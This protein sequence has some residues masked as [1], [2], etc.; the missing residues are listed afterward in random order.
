MAHDV[1]EWLEGLGLGRYAEAFAE[2]EI[3]LPALPHITEEDL[4]EVGVAL[5]ARRLL[6]AAIADLGPS[7]AP[8]QQNVGADADAAGSEAER[9]H[10]TV[11]FCDLVGSTALSEQ[12]DPEDLRQVIA[13]FQ[14]ACASVVADF[15]GY[16]AR[17]MGD[18]MLVYFGYPTAQE[19]AAERSVRAGLGIVDRVTSLPGP[20]GADLHVRVGVATG[21][22]VVGD[23][24][25]EKTA[26]E[27][28]VVGETPNLAARLQG[29]A[30]A[31]TVV[32]APAT[33]RLLGGLFE[34]ED[35]G[36]HDLKGFSEPVRA[37]R[38]LHPTATLSRFEAY[39]G[40][41]L[42]PLV[43]RQE[44]IGFLAEKWNQVRAGEGQVVTLSGEA[45]IG[46][47]RILEAMRAHV[48][49]TDGEAI[50]FQCS[51]HH[52]STALYPFTGYLNRLS[53][54]LAGQAGRATLA[55][56]EALVRSSGQPLAETVP[57]FAELISLPPDD[58]YQPSA[59]DPEQRR[60][61]TLQALA[62]HVKGLTRSSPL[63]LVFEDVHWIDPTSCDLLSQMIEQAASA[64]VLILV[65]FRPGFASPWGAMGVVAHLALSRLGRRQSAD[66]ALAMTGG[67]ALPDEVLGHITDRADG[68]PLFVE[69]MTKSI[70]DSDLMRRTD[71]GFVLEG[72]LSDFAV[73]ETL[74]DSLMARL[75]R[76]SPVK[77]VAQL[78]AVIGREFG[79]GL[80]VAVSNKSDEEVRDAIATL[81]EAELVFRRGW[82]P[83][84][85]YV[86]KH[87]LVQDA[88][89]ESLLKEKRR[90][91]HKAVAMALESK[92][93]ALSEAEPETLAHHLT[94]CGET[95]QAS[96][97]WEKAGR[98]AQE[99]LSHA[100]AA[101][102]ITRALKGVGQDR[103]REFELCLELVSNLRV[104][105]RAEA[106]ERILKRAEPL[107]QQDVDRAKIHYHFGNLYFLSGNSNEALNQHSEALRLARAASSAELECRALSGLADGHYMR[108]RMV[109]AHTQSEECVATARQ[110][111]L[112]HVVASNL[113]ALGNM[114]YLSQGPAAARP[115]FETGVRE[116]VEAENHRAEMIFRFNM[117]AILLDSMELTPALEHAELA[118][119]ACERIGAG[120]WLP[121]MAV[122]GLKVRHLMGENIA[123][124]MLEVAAKAEEIAPAL[125][126]PWA[127]GSLAWAT[128][129]VETATDAMN[130]A[131]AI[132]SSNCVAHN[133]LWFYRDAMDSCLRF[134]RWDQA[135]EY[136]DDLDDFTLAE[137]LAWNR[138]FAAR[139]RALADHGR[140]R[141]S[142]DELRR[143]SEM[144]RNLGFLHSLQAVEGALQ[145]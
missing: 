127:L 97:Y 53:A 6:L 133:Q 108:G 52:Q 61:R 115:M 35:L 130:R 103:A 29:L 10:L 81:T 78:G 49:E 129:D 65:T 37:F 132:I 22:V 112:G 102:H 131:E 142:P 56:V 45:G 107:A 73:P 60:N 74:Q 39:R 119:A 138:F 99:R 144:G 43:G 84:E 25:G 117:S 128:P 40:A 48:V 82:P 51:P 42:T 125:T 83:D 85:V 109:S 8:A 90:R 14:D 79:H 36:E 118:V 5:G 110:Y 77:E 122:C 33:E 70:L 124:E 98:R 58:R 24:V 38:A 91:L 114:R 139:G 34:F 66:I 100:E 50:H 88:A 30:V 20:A 28:A 12:L 101:E 141:A 11:M 2:N 23:L 19:D 1:G 54:A 93:L 64:Q 87:A 137:P 67:T 89:Y 86:F 63:L 75:D 96:G 17:L 136:A 15:G 104:L 80:L 126:G 16:V 57:L 44:E 59:G 120:I 72:P 46:K 111:G 32:V 3:D 9:R 55:G 21:L 31:D 69:E 7:N 105:G 47:S 76:L 113:P 71:R 94:E 135:A 143:I 26:A 92:F 95:G 41:S 68:I 4:K 145:T 13:S 62:N 121:L 140:G 27:R 134:G 116:V 106:T 18:G 123:A